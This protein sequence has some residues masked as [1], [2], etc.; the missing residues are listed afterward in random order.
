MEDRV[1]VRFME[2]EGFGVPPSCSAIW[3][4]FRI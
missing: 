4:W 1:W 2:L 3:N